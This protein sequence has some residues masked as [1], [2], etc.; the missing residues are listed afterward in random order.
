MRGT[1]LQLLSVLAYLLLGIGV[2]WA[3]ECRVSGDPRSSFQ[4][5]KWQLLQD[6]MCLDGPAL[7]LLIPVRGQ[8]GEKV[9]WAGAHGMRGRDEGCSGPGSWELLSHGEVESTGLGTAGL[10]GWGMGGHGLGWTAMEKAS[11]LRKW[12]GMASPPK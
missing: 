4:R 7:D 3:L 12:E 9:D 5:D 11:T 6:Y 2:F 8:P 10:C 1:G